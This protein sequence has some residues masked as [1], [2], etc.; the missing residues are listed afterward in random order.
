MNTT[1]IFNGIT[2]TLQQDAYLAEADNDPHY[3]AHAISPDGEDVII[4]WGITDGMEDDEDEGNRCEWE[5]P[6]SVIR[7]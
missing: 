7:A 3:Q 1:T 4:I 6:S 5:N 2:Y